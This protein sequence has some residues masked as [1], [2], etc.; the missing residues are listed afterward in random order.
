MTNKDKFIAGKA[1]THTKR[2]IA[3]I[4]ALLLCLVCATALCACGN[5]NSSEKTV[6]D[7]SYQVDV[8]LEG[9]SGKATVTSP[10]TVTVENGQAT[11]LIEWSSPNYDL[12][13]VDG[14]DYQ[15]VNTE[16]NSQFE[17]PIPSLDCTLDVSAETT[18]MSQAHTIDY[19]LTFGSGTGATEETEGTES[20]TTLVDDFR[21]TDLGTGAEPIESVSLEYA[22]EF[23]I[24]RYE[25]G[26]ALICTG[27]GA[28]YLVVPEEVS[29]PDGLASDISVIQQPVEDGYIAA[30]SML[31]LVDALDAI[32]QFAFTS[33][34][35]SECS[36][37]GF[38]DALDA[39]TIAYGGKYSAPDYEALASSSCTF[40][41]ESSMINHTPKVKR[42]LESSGITVL[43]EL[44]S[45][46]SDPRARLEWI[47]ALGLILDKEEQADEI[48]QQQIAQIDKVSGLESTNK[49]VAFFYINSNGQVVVRKSGDYV[50]RMIEMAG[51]EYIFKNLDDGLATSTTTLDAES[52]FA[53]AQ[54][55]DILIY[56]ATIDS[57]VNSVQTLLE[58]NGTL[59]QFKAVQEGNVYVTSQDM[60]QQMVHTGDIISDMH[61]AFTG[62]DSN[63]TYLTK[64]E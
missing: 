13:T 6:E 38:D 35:K 45:Y 40:A 52:F 23:T 64:I 43:T 63:L 24:D 14:T 62:D 18:A 33:I 55:A 16:G 11:A 36:I 57:N 15:P 5:T 26:T 61:S 27:D 3:A 25:D 50:A 34:D 8:S 22:K 47:R 21:N 30:T 46:E 59:E 28:R 49:T 4:M 44:S 10:C 19:T 20:S 53:Q 54:D 32:D 37:Q 51:G 12:M 48:F 42:Q 17:I 29:V 2:G 9:G 58:K 56:N 7:G 1:N 60:Y 31:C 41:L 39:G